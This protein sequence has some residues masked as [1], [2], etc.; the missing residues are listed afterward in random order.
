MQAVAHG[1]IPKTPLHR[2]LE[3]V[4][5]DKH[6]LA[7]LAFADVR[8]SDSDGEVDDTSAVLSDSEAESAPSENEENSSPEDEEEAG[9]WLLNL[10]T[11]SS[12][13]AVPLRG[14]KNDPH[15]CDA[16][17]LGCRPTLQLG[18]WSGLGGFHPC[19]H[20]GCYGH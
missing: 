5:E 20:L 11:C 12:H 3:A 6:L 2:G 4:E 17:G 7:Q 18:S 13:R 8:D 14:S 10:R 19:A 15:A 16:W 9:P 1:W